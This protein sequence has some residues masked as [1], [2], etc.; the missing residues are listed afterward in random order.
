MS[1]LLM[2]MRNLRSVVDRLGFRLAVVLAIGLLP[3]MIVSIVRSQSVINEA[4][5]RSQA[6]L[7]GETLQAVREETLLIENAKAVA[8]ALSHTI[9]PVIKDIESC[10][11]VMKGTV[12]DTSFSFAGF[13]DKTGNMPCSSSDASLGFG[14]TSQ[15]EDQVSNPG[16]TVL[17]VEDAQSSKNSVIQVSHPVFADDGMLLGFI[18]VSLPHS[19]LG[20]KDDITSSDA[21]FLTLR[22]DGLVL[23]S[24][25]T[26]EQA[27]LLMP[28]LKTGDSID[29]LPLS[30]Q[31]K[32]IDG[33]SRL[34]S[35]VPVVDD[36]LYALGTWPE[37][38]E[39]GGGFYLHV[40]ALFP[41]LMWIASLGVAWFATSIFVTRDVLK[42][43]RSMRDFAD[44]RVIPDANAFKGAPGE[45]Q[46]VASSFLQMS[47]NILL[48]E[49][50]IEDS[51]RQKDVLLREVH[52]RVKNNLQLISSIMSMQTH[53]S[54]SPEVERLIRNLQDRVNSLATVH[55]NLYQTSGQADVTMDELLGTIVR[56][57]VR[58]GA[59]QD[60]P[61]DLKIEIA[62]L[63]MNPDQAVPLALLVTE[64]LTNALK[65]IGAKESERASLTVR[66]SEP[67]AG[68]G[69]L[70][71]ENSL[72]ETQTARASET[73][74]GLGSELMEAF[75]SQLSGKM[76]VVKQGERFSLS[77]A[78][79]IEE[80]SAKETDFQDEQQ[81]SYKSEK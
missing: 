9:L 12:K 63:K 68:F 76:T 52:H 27:E 54:N 65:Y 73:S 22:A 51:L 28:I 70:V 14:V 4:L 29:T 10:N 6:A 40:P 36:E 55:H 41:F 43:R 61:L 32:G 46:E 64:A 31:Q 17:V 75:A 33:V 1:A 2:H 80:L 77:V 74:S 44:E 15:I 59:K 66:L 26:L 45:L 13:V 42:L 49:A 81:L 72:P 58:M 71:V 39:L 23:T 69:E 30:F 47:E 20:V 35:V 53:L 79:P 38:N 56:Q 3:L 62:P 16:P 8:Q 11:R 24:S 67:N 21:T 48:D 50:Q 78:F 18:S 7:V 19:T 34:Y 25:S 37:S 57:V 5:A 60:L